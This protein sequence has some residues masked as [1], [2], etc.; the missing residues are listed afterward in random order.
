MSY[1]KRQESELLSTHPVLYRRSPIPLSSK[2]LI[3]NLYVRSILIYGRQSR[4]SV[5]SNTNWSSLEAVQNI[6]FWTMTCSPKYVSNKTLLYANQSQSTKNFK[7]KNTKILF[8]KTAYSN[9]HAHIHSLDRSQELFT[10]YTHTW[11]FDWSTY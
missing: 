7:H 2:C 8:N 11:P 5:M 1:I 4:G 10:K 6:A 9:K 3:L